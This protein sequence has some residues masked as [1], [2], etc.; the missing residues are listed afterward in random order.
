[1]REPRRDIQNIAGLHLF[2]DYGFERVDLQQVRVRTMLLHRHLFAHA[3][4]AAT[5]TL[6]DKHVV[7]VEMRADAASRNGK[8]D[9]QIV[10]AP[11]GKGAERVHQRRRRLVPVIDRLYQQRPVIFAQMVVALKRTV[12]DLPFT[13]LMT[14]QATVDFA[15]HRQSGQLVRA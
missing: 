10:D 5:G 9:H 1:M 3:P 8:R 12:A 2:I 13:V 15:L 14:D 6:N 7:L 4:A 11:V